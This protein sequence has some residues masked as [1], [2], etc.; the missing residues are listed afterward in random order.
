MRVIESGKINGNNNLELIERKYPKLNIEF[1]NKCAF[2]VTNN[3]NNIKEILECDKLGKAFSEHLS[4]KLFKI[5]NQ[6]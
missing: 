3:Q 6:L 4:N 1:I 2:D 5:N